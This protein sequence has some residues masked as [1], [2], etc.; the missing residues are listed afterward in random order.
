MKIRYGF[1]TNSSSSS[2]IINKSEKI[3]T[4]EDLE[5]YLQNL[6]EKYNSI[7]FYGRKIEPFYTILTSKNKE[8]IKNMYIDYCC[9]NAMS[10]ISENCKDTYFSLTMNSDFT[11]LIGENEFGYE[12]LEDISKEIPNIKY[13]NYHMG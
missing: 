1:V 10:K 6:I 8:E 13:C 5:K 11:L 7:N 4:K 3:K 9:W 2:F 12:M